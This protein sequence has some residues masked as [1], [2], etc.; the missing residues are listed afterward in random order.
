MTIHHQP[1]PDLVE[2]AHHAKLPISTVAGPYGHPFHPILITIPI[3]AW[4][5]SLVFDIAARANSAGSRPLVD[6]SYWLIGIGIIGAL[7][8][9]V[10]G[11]M[12]LSRI[13]RRTKAMRVGLTHMTMN[14]VIV[15]LFV[16]NFLWRH[17]SYDVA[18]KVR[19]GQL[20]LSAVAI[21]ML[22]VSGW[23]GGMLAYRYGVRVADEDTQFGGYA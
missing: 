15:G 17:S 12:D 19:V 7:L 20:A 11:L 4:T 8:A 5:S 14:L 1:A 22:L 13:P 2:R 18:S 23:L 3:G 6:A 10:F 9:A 16:V 21:G